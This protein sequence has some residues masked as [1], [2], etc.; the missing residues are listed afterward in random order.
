MKFDREKYSVWKLPNLLLIHWVINPA[1]AFNELILGQRLPKITLIDKTSDAPLLER[2]YIPCP[3]CESLH[4]AR[5]WSKRNAFG[6]WFGYVCPSCSEK[7]PCLWNLTSLLILAVTFPIWVPIKH[8]C[9]SKWLQFEKQRL[10]KAQHQPLVKASPKLWLK[11]GVLF[12]L[13]MFIVTLMAKG[14]TGGI[15]PQNIPFYALVN[16]SAG[17]FVGLMMKVFL[18][19]KKK[20]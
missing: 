4:D 11:L 20:R 5:L 9:E 17:A 15:D 18:G 13:I 19:W 2:Q 6:H 16:F 8:F 10:S 14:A 7:I 1:L 12:G 3:H